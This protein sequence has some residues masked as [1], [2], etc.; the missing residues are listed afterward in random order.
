MI[1]SMVTLRWRAALG[2]VLV[3][4]VLGLTGGAAGAGPSA[5]SRQD[6]PQRVLVVALPRVVWDDID[7]AHTPHLERFFDEAA[8]ASMS[9]RTIGPKTEPGAAYLTIGA[10]NRADTEDP[11]TDGQ[12]ANRGES[13]DQE[14]ADDVYHRRTGRVP[15]GE[16]L[17]LTF[18]EQ[19]NRN[20]DLL[21]GTEPGA[22]ASTL[23]DND[24]SMGVVGNADEPDA[25]GIM[26]HVALAGADATGQVSAGNVSASLLVRDGAAPFGVRLDSDVVVESTSTAFAGGADVV[27]VEMSDLERAEQARMQSLPAQADAQFRRALEESD[28]LFGRLME[29]MDPRRDLVMVVG[30]DAPQAA[31]QLTVFG[32]S[33]PEVVRGWATS[34]TTRRDG[35]M[36]LTDIAPTILARFGIARPDSMNDTPSTST[37]SSASLADRIDA[38]QRDNER[39][40]FRDKAMGPITVSFIVLL[41]LML[42]L[43]V[44]SV[45]RRPNWSGP[46]QVMALAVLAVP[47]MTYLGGLLGYGPF[48]TAS[49]GLLLLAAAVVAGWVANRIGRGDAI[50]PP[51][52]L[53]T[54]CLTVLGVDIVTG[55]NLQ[56]NTVFGYSPI[57]AG[58][59]AGFGNQAFSL[60]AISTLLVATAGW[61]E[62]ERRNPGG[63]LRRRLIAVVGLFGV[64]IVLDGA[65]QFG[66]DVGGVLASVPAYAVCAVMLSGRRVRARMIVFIAAATIAV[67]GL[68]AAI[69]LSRPSESRTHLGR[70]ADKLVS[71]DFA[72]VLQRKLES[73]ISV[74]TSTIWTLVIPVALAFFAYLTWRP[75]RVLRQI[76][77]AYP[78]FRPF[79]VSALTLGL[80]AWGLNDSGV[81]MPA[82]MLTIALPYTAILALHAVRTRPSSDDGDDGDD[83]DED[84]GVV[85]P[86]TAGSGV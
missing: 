83:E 6:P 17:A 71:G 47:T 37:N 84:A 38:M 52:I 79:G 21:Y 56:L 12:A 63:P 23:E 7:S 81:S 64:V 53:G 45:A 74:L 8:V 28:A 78:T 16:V 18:P 4:V 13:I 29:S 76:Q 22:L 68:F 43:V 65:P 39:A 9:T 46:L 15:S 41:V 51:L 59:F 25:R 42:G 75:G 69:D 14:S 73:N 77:D 31:E 34:P 67:L 72:I 70:F 49:Y 80:L 58:R 82:M 32:M 30:P 2:L 50:R 26:R 27:V 62:A 40:M 85:P 86:V 54:L 57:V 35:F 61:E 11:L 66:S 24:R 60:L 3:A 44:F 33:G 1:G 36:T 5:P 10:G 48:V 55:G 20:D 19:V